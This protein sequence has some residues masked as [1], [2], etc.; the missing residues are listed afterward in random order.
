MD[1]QIRAARKIMLHTSICQAAA[2]E[3][4]RTAGS[5][6]AMQQA[7]CGVCREGGW[8]QA[9]Q[10]S[11]RACTGEV[12]KPLIHHVQLAREGR[13]GDECGDGG[14]QQAEHGVDNAVELLEG[15]RRQRAR[16]RARQGAVEAASMCH[17]VSAGHFI[18]YIDS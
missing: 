2:I 17:V 3:G 12:Q 4:V 1:S 9:C 5:S 8:Q 15:P 16:L 14:A 18:H 7:A 6:H 10:V 13:G 11:K